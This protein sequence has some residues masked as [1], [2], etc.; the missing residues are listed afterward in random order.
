M[1]KDQIKSLEMSVWLTRSI[2]SCGTDPCV[3]KI[4]RSFYA[5]INGH[6][7]LSNVTDQKA[8]ESLIESGRL[9][10]D[11]NGNDYRPTDKLLELLNE[12]KE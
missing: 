7:K 9:I 1:T 4:G 2:N 6:S 3:T 11:A 12:I 5:D 10:V 8:I